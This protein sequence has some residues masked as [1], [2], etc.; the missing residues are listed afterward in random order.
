[1]TEEGPRLPARVVA[2]GW[3]AVAP[4]TPQPHRPVLHR[5]RVMLRAVA[6]VAI[7]LLVVT[8]ALAGQLNVFGLVAVVVTG[9]AVTVSRGDLFVSLVFYGCAIF[10]WLASGASATSWWAIAVAVE[11]LVAHAARTLSA[12]GPA[13]APLP[14]ALV[15]RWARNTA[16]VAAATVA[17]GLAGITMTHGGLTGSGYAAAVL[18]IG[19]MAAVA[20]LPM[21][22][23]ERDER[24]R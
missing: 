23:A 3:R 16:W 10:L 7:A 11:L 14:R 19:L 4:W 17:L 24:S 2:R 15:I 5:D 8:V 13:D 6:A 9:C 21:L 18:L 1:M 22:F 20:A 12:L